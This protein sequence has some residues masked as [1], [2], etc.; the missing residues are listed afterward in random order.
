MY[1]LGKNCVAYFGE[2]GSEID[3]LVIANNIQDLNINFTK[4]EADTSTRGDG[5]YKTRAATQREFEI[6]LQAK[7]VDNS[8][9]C[10]SLIDSFNNDSPIRFAALTGPYTEGSGPIADMSVFTLTRNEALA[11][12]VWY[13]VVLKPTSNIGWHSPPTETTSNLPTTVT[14]IDDDWGFWSGTNY[15]LDEVN[16]ATFY[17]GDDSQGAASS[18]PELIGHGFGFDVPAEAIITGFEVDIALDIAEDGEDGVGFGFFVDET[19][20]PG[21]WNVN[22]GVTTSINT[23]LAADDFYGGPALVAGLTPAIVNNPN[24]GFGIKYG[25]FDTAEPFHVE[26]HWSKLKVKILYEL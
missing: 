20:L 8:S 22:V 5:G 4:E 21:Q 24:F 14:L 25:Y 9:F 13:D 11:D 1:S 12:A 2:P 6:S 16:S 3:E 19:P 7:H 18:I 15:L 23:V 17:T 10:E 26:L